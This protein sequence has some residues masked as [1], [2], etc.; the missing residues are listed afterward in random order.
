MRLPL[1]CYV[2]AKENREGQSRDV[3]LRKE[4]KARELR[5]VCGLC[6]TETQLTYPQ[7]GCLRWVGI[8]AAMIPQEE[9]VVS[10]TL[11]RT[12]GLGSTQG[13]SEHQT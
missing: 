3:Y 10:M 8:S 4:C 7:P 5:L 11:R 12:G 6:V 9:A 13:G 1:R 2:S